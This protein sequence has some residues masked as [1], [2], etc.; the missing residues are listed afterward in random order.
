MSIMSWDP[1][2]TL[3]RLDRDFD[4]LVRRTWGGPRG[5]AASG[6]VPPVEMI[7][8]GS[9]VLVRLELPGIDVDRD[10][11]VEVHD[12]LLTV[13]GQR[14]SDV[15]E[16]SDDHK[17]LVREHRYGSF[18]REFALPPGVS[19]DDVT[20]HYDQGILEIR[21]TGVAQPEPKPQRV[22][23]TKRSEAGGRQVIEGSVG[24]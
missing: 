21:I 4:E 11:E 18:R 15:T 12:G 23:V 10:V 1:F 2:T 17:I 16:Q 22:E 13:S 5:T 6:F 3:S 8:D 9:D 19:G 20:A 24:D 7:T 14:D